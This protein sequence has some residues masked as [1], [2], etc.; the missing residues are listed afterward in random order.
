MGRMVYT[1][2]CRRCYGSGD[3]TCPACHGDG[4][5]YYDGGQCDRCNGTGEV[6]C[7]QCGG[8]GEVESDD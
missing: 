6:T 4:Y 8:S 5:D 3:M 2:M 7:D 1:C